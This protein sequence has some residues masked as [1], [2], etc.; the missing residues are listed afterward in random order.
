MSTEIGFGIVE[1]QNSHA[2]GSPAVGR[3]WT[4]PTLLL[5]R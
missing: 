2:E 1:A 5:N 4:E 3:G